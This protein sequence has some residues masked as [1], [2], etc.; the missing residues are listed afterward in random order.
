MK[1]LQSVS[2]GTK[3]ARVK[4]DAPEH[5][6]PTVTS[7][8]GEIYVIISRN[9]CCLIYWSLKKLLSKHVNAIKV[10]ALKQMNIRAIEF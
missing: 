5:A 1:D 6:L 8:K 3:R 2:T 10:A 9:V 7:T 4:D